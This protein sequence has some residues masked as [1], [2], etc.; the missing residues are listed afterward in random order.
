MNRTQFLTAA[1]VLCVSVPASAEF[2]TGN[3]LLERL[4]SK[5][6]GARVL[7]LGYIMGAS[8]A[9]N[10]V[11]HCLPINATAGQVRDVVYQWLEK[12]PS[13]RHHSADSI[14]NAMLSMVY[15]CQGGAKKENL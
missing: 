6:E 13:V 5:D 3:D 4:R 12:T 7:A 14:V 2:L 10:T 8:D 9:G 11:N 15:P 1:L